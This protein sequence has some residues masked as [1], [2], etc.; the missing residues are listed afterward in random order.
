MLSFFIPSRTSPFSRNILVRY[1]TFT[2]QDEILKF[3][4][5]KA[6]DM[7]MAL[8]LYLH[9]GFSFLENFPELSGFN[10]PIYCS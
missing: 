2:M 3:V 1:P 10:Q 5:R 9:I 4:F 7:L 8:C 6:K